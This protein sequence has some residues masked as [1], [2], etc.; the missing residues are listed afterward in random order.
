MPK[1]LL[2]DLDE[3]LLGNRMDSFLPAYLQAL[4]EYLAP[5]IAPDKMIAALTAGT[6]Q[7][8][9]NLQ[10]DCMLRE[11]FDETFFPALGLDR[12]QIQPIIDR[13][14]VE[15][16]PSLQRHTHTIPLAQE[17]VSTSLQRGYQVAIATSP[18]FPRSAIEQ[19]LSWAGLPHSQYPFSLVSSYEDFHFAKPNPAYFAEVLARLGWPDG[20]VLMVG[21]DLEQDIIPASRLGVATYWINSEDTQ[22]DPG[23]AV[24]FARGSLSELTPW[25]ESHSS[26]GLTPTYQTPE[27]L[28]SILRATPAVLDTWCRNLT[29]GEWR[30]RSKPD[31]WSALEVVSHLRDTDHEV[32]L[33]RLEKV[34]L[35]K[36]PFIAGIDTDR[37]AEE[38]K[39]IQQDGQSARLSYTAS[40][41]EAIALLEKLSPAD[42]LRSARHAILGP[43]TLLEL[44]SIIAAH[45]RLHVQQLL[46]ELQ[47]GATV[48]VRD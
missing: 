36:N 23:E 40:R 31:T 34:L 39:Y 6:R 20:D 32:H 24:E 27:A 9:A 22:D 48:G 43:T 13:F 47:A 38:R 15:K 12:S 7:M 19:R 18:L 37:W 46:A 33:P 2:F 1:T 42:W 10:P 26:N 41:M 25:L 45:D 14:Y 28:L 35:S 30:V 21:D 5:Y 11:S 44:V 8:V 4:A 29:P 3:T 17:T 16:F